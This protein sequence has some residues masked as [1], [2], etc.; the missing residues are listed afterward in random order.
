MLFLGIIV[1]FKPV[2]TEDKIH[3]G[4]QPI[5]RENKNY[6]LVGEGILFYKLSILDSPWQYVCHS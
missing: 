1:A 6:T 2:L 5:I 4:S 3:T